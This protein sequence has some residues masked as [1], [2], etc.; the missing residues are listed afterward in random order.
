MRLWQKIFLCVLA[1]VLL[2]I[3]GTAVAITVSSH[4]ANVDRAMGQAVSSHQYLAAGLVNRVFYE[5]LRQEKALLSD[6]E[7]NTLLQ[8]VTLGGS[9]SVSGFALY[10]DGKLV[11]GYQWERPREMDTLQQRIQ[12]AES[13]WCSVLDLEDGQRILT[14]SEEQIEGRSFQ[15]FC[16]ADVS[17]LYEIYDRQI[18]WIRW[19]STL[20]AGVLAGL[21]L[22]VVWYFLAPLKRINHLLRQ[23][24]GG[25]Y[26]RR[27]RQEGSA[28][29]RELSGNIN[30]MAD[31][32]EQHVE[33]IRTLAEG[34]KRFIDSFAHEMKTPLTSI[35]GF[36][37]LLRLKREVSPTQRQEYAGIIVEETRR[38]QTLSG[39]LLE[40]SLADH[41][42]LELE[43]LFLPGL[44][45][46]LRESAAIGLEKRGVG[47]FVSAEPVWI[48]ADRELFGSLLLNLI[49]N[50][51]KASR[52]GGT[53][54]VFALRER[55][56]VHLTVTDHGIGMTEEQLRH[57]A[58][59]FYMADKSRSRRAG[60]AGLGLAL[61][62]EIVK[63][64]H[65]Q[66]RMESTPGA[67]TTVHLLMEELIRGGDGA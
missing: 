34:R 11:A 41:A 27:V 64:H 48:Q 14:S 28:E 66:L 45:E 1:F 25:D 43:P 33:E 31:A 52:S 21:L 50:A 35:L 58:E 19:V 65:M 6:A 32:V 54:E 49:D 36:A 23:I 30:L 57:A 4:R 56:K 18:E 12:D 62:A 61:C 55:G 8:Q 63:C 20:V 39:K 3:D 2:G 51:A 42:A 59:P 38:L 16:L 24:A 17:G 26:R 53:V 37:D 67:G 13:V 7:I 10:R 5:R 60:G 22:L 47:L 15:L 9:D 46:E 44:L 40:L 29:L